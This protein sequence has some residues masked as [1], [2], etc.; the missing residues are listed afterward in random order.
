MPSDEKS[1]DVSMPSVPFW[2]LP[3]V[4]QVSEIRALTAAI[5]KIEKELDDLRS[6][7]V[8]IGEHNRMRE[9]QDHLWDLSQTVMPQ[10]QERMPQI[11]QMW[12]ERSQLQVGLQGLKV[13]AAVLGFL[14]GIV[15]VGLAVA[16]AG[17]SLHFGK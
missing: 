1:P 4:Q 17:V 6:N 8:P 10:W 11:D 3:L 13:A 9:R 5:P 15:I 2:A 12:D 14:Q 7:S 16:Q